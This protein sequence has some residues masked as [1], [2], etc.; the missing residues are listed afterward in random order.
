[1]TH[2]HIWNYLNLSFFA[3]FVKKI[4]QPFSSHEARKVALISVSLVL[5][6]T[7]VY[8]ARPRIWG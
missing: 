3:Y 7:P 6:R 5:S 8:T 2:S 1:M 4:V